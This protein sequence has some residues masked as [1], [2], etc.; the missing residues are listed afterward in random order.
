MSGYGVHTIE[1]SFVAD[2]FAPKSP[3][4]EDFSARFLADTLKLEISIPLL[5]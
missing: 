5:L 2:F 4:L 3:M 1:V